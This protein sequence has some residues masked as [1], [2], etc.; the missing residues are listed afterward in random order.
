MR[1]G[2]VDSTPVQIGTTDQYFNQTRRH[3]SGKGTLSKAVFALSLK[4]DI[5]LDKAEF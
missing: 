4:A 1:A 3:F 2:P 5:D